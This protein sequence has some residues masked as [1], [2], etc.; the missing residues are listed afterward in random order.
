MA[1][2][3]I[4]IMGGTFNPIHCGHIRM[5][6]TAREKAG[7]DRVLVVPTGN[8][9]HKKHIAP[10]EDRWRMVCAACAQEECL[11]P[12]RI[13][14]DRQGVIYTVDTL[15]LLHQEHPK[16][17]LFYI[18]GAD[19]L[20]ELHNWRRYEEVLHMCTFLV[21]PRPWDVTPAALVEQRRTLEALGGR[22][23][24]LEMEPMDVSSTDIRQALDNDQP[25]ALLPVPVREYCAV[26]GLYGMDSR[27]PHAEGWLDRLF[28]DLSVKRFAHTL[29][30]AHTARHLAVLHH[31]DAYRAEVA[32]LLHDCAKCLPLKEM[33][34]IARDNALTGDEDILASGALLHSVTGAHLASSVYGVEDPSVLQA[35]L[36]HTTGSPGMTAL[37]MIVYLADKIEPTRDSYPLLEKVRMLAQLSLTRAMIASMEGTAGHVKKGGKALHPQTLQTLE[38]LHTLDANS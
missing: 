36:R 11:T 26:R 37:D 29:A 17:E 23:I 18:I 35:I 31:A 4:G 16:A 6:L 1:K 13:E 21:C 22:F 12:S 25:T 24:T 34:R 33:Q 15:T 9:P 19:T 7:L 3:R 14:L 8:P 32:A 28:A 2:E 10:A 38:W 5:A 20:M 27:I 30:V